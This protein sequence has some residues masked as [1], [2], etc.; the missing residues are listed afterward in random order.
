MSQLYFSILSISFSISY[1]PYDYI[2]QYFF[3]LHYING[4]ISNTGPNI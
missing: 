4:S 2:G 3:N 1:N